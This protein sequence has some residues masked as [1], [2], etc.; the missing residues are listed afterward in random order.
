MMIV[1]FQIYRV[2]SKPSVK[3]IHK[4]TVKCNHERVLGTESKKRS[5]FIQYSSRK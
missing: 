3:C 2:T 5:S 4:R 1:T